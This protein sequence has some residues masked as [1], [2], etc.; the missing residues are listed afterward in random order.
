M[1]STQGK[2]VSQLDTRVFR[3][4]V[5]AVVGAAAISL[6]FTSWRVSLGLLVG[7]VLS[8]MNLH[9][10]RSSV[11]AGFSLAFAAGR[12]QFTLARYVLR[13]FVIGLIVF[14]AYKLDVVSFPATI[15]GLCSFVVA[16]FAE[17]FREF[18]LAIFHREE[19]G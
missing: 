15:V 8:L 3:T 6:F 5:I 13:Y 16:L 12:P 2:A 17:A 11:A 19:T 10:M 4:M 1:N 14:L 9:W 7:G 18:Y